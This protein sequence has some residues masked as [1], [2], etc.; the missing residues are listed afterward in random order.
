MD[1]DVYCVCVCV[2]VRACVS[3]CVR[4]R[5]CVRAFVCVCACVC[6]ICASTW[7]A[8]N[9]LFTSVHVVCRFAGC[10]FSYNKPSPSVSTLGLLPQITCRVSY[11]VQSILQTFFL[12]LLRSIDTPAIIVR[13]ISDRWER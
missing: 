11:L 9:Q 12:G 7:Y 1:V 8:N 2:C 13:L 3:I 5:M 6:I 10:V 4:V